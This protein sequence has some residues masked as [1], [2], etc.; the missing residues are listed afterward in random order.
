[1]SEEMAT[2]RL[3]LLKEAF[4][5]LSRVAVLWNAANPAKA[6]DWR[7]TQR[8]A[9]ALAVTLQSH[10]VRG[11]DDFASAFAAMTKQRP[12]ALLTLPDPLILHSRTA[13]TAFAAKERLPTIYGGPEYTHA[14]GLMSYDSSVTDNYRR[15]AVYVYK[16]LQG[17]KPAELA[18]AQPTKFE[19]IINLKTARALAFTIPQSILLRADEVIE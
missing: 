7:E 1:M 2:K 4:P 10:E 12:D 3:E 16:I 5:R 11:P 15:V 8:A 13:I 19:L 9:R 14:G 17:A 18:V 6:V